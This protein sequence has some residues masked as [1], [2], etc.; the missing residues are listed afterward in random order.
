MKPYVGRLATA[1]GDLQQATAWLKRH[2]AAAPDNAAAVVTDYLHLMGLV[3][4]GYMWSRIAEAGRALDAAAERMRGKLVTGRLFVERM[5]PE[6]LLHLARI[7]L[8]A[9]NLMEWPAEA[10]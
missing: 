6:T 2:A 10:F 8:G 3:V 7:R 5:L 1:L 4:L 9:A